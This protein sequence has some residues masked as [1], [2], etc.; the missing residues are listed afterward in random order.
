MSYSSTT[1]DLAVCF[2]CFLSMAMFWMQIF[3]ALMQQHI[4]DWLHLH[5][6]LTVVCKYTTLSAGYITLKKSALIWWSYG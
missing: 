3:Y 2:T 6:Y 5:Q 4:M 1:F